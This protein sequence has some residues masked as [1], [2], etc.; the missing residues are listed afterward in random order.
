MQNVCVSIRHAHE[1]E[2]AALSLRSLVAAVL[3]ALQLWLVARGVL[4]SPL[5]FVKR[6]AKARWLALLVMR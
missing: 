5:L 1:P 3:V 4:L 6:L 2:S